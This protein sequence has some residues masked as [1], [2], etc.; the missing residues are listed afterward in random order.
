[1]ERHASARL[2]DLLILESVHG[3]ALISIDLNDMC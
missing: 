2:V 3:I 1:M